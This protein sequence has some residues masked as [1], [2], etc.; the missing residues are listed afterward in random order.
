MGFAA[1]LSA[2][3]P[4][5]KTGKKPDPQT[6]A[7]HGEARIFAANPALMPN[8]HQKDSVRWIA[9]GIGQ[10]HRWR[11]FEAETATHVWVHSLSC[12]ALFF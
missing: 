6:F 12:A 2:H 10:H 4:A 3:V 9:I 11:I 7:R 8:P 5:D 1:R